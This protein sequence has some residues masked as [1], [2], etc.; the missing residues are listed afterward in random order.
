MRFSLRSIL[1]AI[2]GIAILRA[3]WPPF[4]IEWT[5]YVPNAPAISWEGTHPRWQF[6]V[7]LTAEVL[8]VA[9]WFGWWSRK[10][11]NTTR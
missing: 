1:I 5:F 3:V 9:F 2:A 4:E 7:A 10:A 11:R 6:F 8:A